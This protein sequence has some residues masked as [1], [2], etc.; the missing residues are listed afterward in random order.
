M[1]LVSVV[2]PTRNRATLLRQAIKSALGQSWPSIEVIVIDEASEDRTPDVMDAFGDQIEVIR[3]EEPEGLP[4]V[5][6]IGASVSSGDYVL[7]LDDDDLL[8]PTHV[9]ELVRFSEDLSSAQIASSGWRRF[10]ISE[11]GKVIVDPVVRPPARWKA[12]EAIAEI[13]GHDP[14]C[15]IWTSSVLWPRRVLNEVEFDEGLPHDQEVDFYSRVLLAGYEFVGTDAGMA[16]YRTHGGGRRSTPNSKSD[17]ISSA[18]CRLRHARLLRKKSHGESYSDSVTSG[19]RSGLMR[20][21]FGL[22]AQQGLT[23]WMEKVDQEYKKWGGGQYYLPQPPR[24]R[25]KKFFLQ[26]ALRIGGPH[27]VGKI[28][29]LRRSFAQQ[30][31]A[32][33]RSVE[34]VAYEDLMTSLTHESG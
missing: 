6:N 20:V 33:S 4:A 31:E 24:N 28:L 3:N 14:G 2:I 18:K 17:L 29:R 22:C 13:F 12:P 5:R 1:K 30:K 8:H 7:H 11:K 21:L 15:L 34:M 9:E 27:L 32:T 16:Y 19:I 26:A 25:L 10:R 23:D